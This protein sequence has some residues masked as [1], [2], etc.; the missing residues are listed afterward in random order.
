M[1]LL[2]THLKMNDYGPRRSRNRGVNDEQ[3]PLSE[4]KESN[5]YPGV[6]NSFIEY[7]SDVSGESPLEKSN[8]TQEKTGSII[9]S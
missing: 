1:L 3:K 4:V 2:L 9:N 7:F 5:H 6:A 8:A